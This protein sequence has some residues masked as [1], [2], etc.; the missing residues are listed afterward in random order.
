MQRPVLSSV[1]R[2]SEEQSD[3]SL[4]DNSTKKSKSKNESTL[5]FYSPPRDAS[6]PT[7]LEVTLTAATN[8]TNNEETPSQQSLHNNSGAAATAAFPQLCNSSV[9]ATKKYIRSA[10]VDDISKQVDAIS[11]VAKA[12]ATNIND[13]PPCKQEITK[14][15]RLLYAWGIKKNIPVEIILHRISL[16]EKG[17]CFFEGSCKY[18]FLVY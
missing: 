17:Y 13:Q 18:C 14:Q 11:Y 10:V 1:Q 9:V 8:N 6:P 4:G 5:F 16:A 7:N 2:K 3:P 15:K 12:T